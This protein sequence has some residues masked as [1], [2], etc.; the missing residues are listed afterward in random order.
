MGFFKKDNR[1]G[2][3]MD[4]IKCDLP[5]T[6][7]LIWKWSPNGEPSKKEDS[8]R[9]KSKLTVN[10]G[11]VAVFVY[12]DSK[13][14]SMDFIEGD[15]QTIELRTANLPVL[16]SIM[17]ATF[18]G[19]SPFPARVYFINTAASNRLAFFIPKLPLSKKHIDNIMVPADIKGSM[20]FRIT[21]YRQFLESYSLA[22][23]TFDDLREKLMDLIMKKARA[24][25]TRYV[26]TSEFSLL[27]LDSCT[28]DVSEEMYRQLCDIIAR[29][30]ALTLVRVD[31]GMI[32][33]DEKSLGYRSLHK[34]MAQEAAET[35]EEHIRD[36]K[37]I[38]REEMQRRTRYNTETD[39]FGTHN[40]NIQGEVAR[41]AAESLGNMGGSGGGD[42]LNPAGMMAGMMLGGAVGGNLANMVGGVMNN[43]SAGTVPP[44]PPVRTMYYELI[45]G[46]QQG[47]LALSDLK[48]H[49][50]RGLVERN[51]YI[52][53]QNTPDWAEAQTFPELDD[54][55]RMMPPPPPKGI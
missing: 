16:T 46:Q 21:D 29:E 32:S 4:V 17:G 5:S 52:W 12:G 26:S 3:M 42:G 33:P 2:G 55:F 50:S 35:D 34:Q 10:P 53:K 36:L 14:S 38:E 27:Q 31:I 39:Y 20:L 44:P 11:Q 18:G 9:F 47:P 49:I 22:P 24:I 7:Y 6:D 30:Q 40:L 41:T 25:I 37:R 45:N 28:D 48:E 13:E 51:T 15:G 54:M 8:I 19:D 23:L 1:E 43:V